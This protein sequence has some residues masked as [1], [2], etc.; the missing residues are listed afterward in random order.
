MFVAVVWRDRC[1]ESN[2]RPDGL[3]PEITR[4]LR[5]ATAGPPGVEP[6]PTRLEL[7]VLPL[8]HG[9]MPSG[10]PGSNGS[11]RS[12]APVLSPLSYVRRRSTPGWSRTSVHRLRRAVLIH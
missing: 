8:H 9:P 11:P 10:R 3:L 5:P 7:V 1:A 12:G 2:R 6:G 4:P